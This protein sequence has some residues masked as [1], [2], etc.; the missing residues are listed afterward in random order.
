MAPGLPVVAGP[1]IPTSDRFHASNQSPSLFTYLTRRSAS[2]SGCFD[3][4][5]KKEKETKTVSINRCTEE[6]GQQTEEKKRLL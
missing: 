4:T 5:E 6:G 2:P 3:R 1:S